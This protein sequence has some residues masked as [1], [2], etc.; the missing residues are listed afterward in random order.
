M[1]RWQLDVGTDPQSKRWQLTRRFQRFYSHEGVTGK[2]IEVA[3]YK[4]YDWHDEKANARIAKNFAHAAALAKSAGFKGLALD[5]EPYVRIWD[6][7]GGSE[8]TPIVYHE[9]RAIGRAGPLGQPARRSSWR[10]RFEQVFR[11]RIVVRWVQ[12]CGLCHRTYV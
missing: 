7:V 8:L 9:G 4:W 6:E 3:I 2:F 1:K 12:A 10:L 5:L 11:A